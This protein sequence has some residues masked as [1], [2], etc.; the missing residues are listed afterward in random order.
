MNNLEDRLR[1]TLH[2]RAGTVPES[3]FAHADLTARLAGR[4]RRRPLHVVAAAAVVVVA[5]AVPVVLTQRAA[6]VSTPVVTP[7]PPTW[8]GLGEYDKDGVR[9]SAGLVVDANGKGWC[10]DERV[11]DG[12]QEHFA[13]YGVPAWDNES[14][15]LPDRYVVVAGVLGTPREIYDNVAGPLPDLLLFVTAPKITSLDVAG[16]NGMPAT[17]HMLARTAQATYFL[18]DF[19]GSTRGMTYLARDQDG[20]L[21]TSNR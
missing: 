16:A 1:A 8:I 7:A 20:T 15:S 18:A 6:P 3:S 4:N 10:V 11:D 5:V 2:E 14:R 12:D 19:D 9:T 21:V 13:C 17:V